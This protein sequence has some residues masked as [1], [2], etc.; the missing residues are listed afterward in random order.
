M[1]YPSECT[2]GTVISRR[3]LL[4]VLPIPALALAAPRRPFLGITVMP[5]DYQVEGIEAVL[6]NLKERAG[7]TAVATSPYVMQPSDPEHGQRQPP[8]DAGAGGVRLLDRPL[9]GKRELYTSCSPS[10]VPNLKLYQGLAYQPGAPDEL[11]RRQGP[12][13]R[14]FLQ[15]AKRAGLK[16]YFQIQ[17]VIPPDYIVTSGG[18]VDLDKPR[19]P[20]GSVP[21]RRVGNTGSLASMDIRRYT[22]AL[23]TD[24]CRQYPEIDGIRMDWP[25]Y[26]QYTLD[27]EFLDF[28]KPAEAAAK[29][30]GFDFEQM[31]RDA[32]ALYTKLHG[33]LTNAEVSSTDFA[34]LPFMSRQPG[35]QAL[36]RFKAT[37]V[38]ELLQGIRE[39]LT[40]AGGAGKELV[41]NAFPEPFSFASGMDYR[42]AAKWSNGIS[43]KL[44]TMHWPMILRFYGDALMEANPGLNEALVARRLA[45]I[46]GIMDDESRAHLKDW[47]Y[48]GPD[49]PHRAGRDAQARKIAYAQKEAGD[50]PVYALAHGYGPVKD[51]EERLG[52][53]WAAS[54]GRVWINRYGYLTDEKLAVVGRRK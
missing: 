48:P 32:G 18:P 52:V 45:R 21:K 10:F 46:F 14:K 26:P 6:R 39:A 3:A 34:L 11:T 1:V 13:V 49:T 50:T 30:L 28:S 4:S 15:A 38:E 47:E 12:I 44:Y 23:I 54:D 41:P 42:R 31:R 37:L 40:A 8:I 19:L 9:W 5:E 53:A 36:G 7:A 35:L 51:F 25:E 24:L 20:N 2:V 22:Q 17:S 27:D 43:V 33:G 29:R 16:T